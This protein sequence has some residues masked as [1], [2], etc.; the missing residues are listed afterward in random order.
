M[1]WLKF[2]VVGLVVTMGVMIWHQSIDNDSWYV[3]AEG[4][5]I[6]N[7]GIYYT[8][9]LSMHEDLNVTVQN[10]GF[11]VIYYLIHML[12][13][14]V[15]LYVG[16]LIL[17][18]L[19]CFII[20]KIC[21]LISDK[22]M[23]L[24][25]TITV[26]TDL[27]LSYW[28]VVTRAQMVSYVIM[29]LVIYLLELYIRKKDTKYL[30]WIP[31]LSLIQINL[32]ASLWPMILVVLAVYIIDSFKIKK[33]HLDGYKTKPLL[34]ALG[35]SIL[36]GLLNPYG[37]KMM[38]FILTSYGV[39]EADNYINELAAFKPLAFGFTILLYI[40][41]VMAICLYI[42][43]D[44]RRIKMR[45]LI[46]T[47]GFLALGL[48][49][50]K[51]MS[52]LIL[53]LLFPMAAIYRDVQIDKKWRR[54]SIMMASWAGVMAVCLIIAIA[55]IAMPQ[56]INGPREELIATVDKL[57][58]DVETG[59]VLN[60]KELKIYTGYDNGGFLE[61]RGYK[62]YIDP[63]MEVFIKSN[64]GKEDIFKEFRDMSTGKI[65]VAD[66][67][68]KYDFD[69]MVVME[70]EDV[71]YDLENEEY[72]LIYDSKD[73]ADGKATRE[74]SEAAGEDDED[75]ISGIRLYKK[76]KMWYN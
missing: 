73:R 56:T 31:L 46:L 63:R 21:M 49:T 75:D 24:S 68:E 6:V 33:L 54:W 11:A 76:N 18:L 10:Y 67:I 47:F 20:Y 16:T 28:F 15:G 39:P 32:H 12:F 71:L 40:S 37:V 25:L 66:F 58:E 30:W 36:V 59:G 5:E 8:D 44:K 26:L 55:A 74:D 48:N 50:I 64:N 69:Y 42:F 35:A 3:L 62:P 23:N 65:K 57:D 51:G 19:L 38:T 70:Y 43:G 41:I 7:N 45:W 72:E 27:L 13:G 9:Q 53:V 29:M 2:L 22:N 52:N 14:P 34:I 60:K 61:Y 17:N 1:K 4:R